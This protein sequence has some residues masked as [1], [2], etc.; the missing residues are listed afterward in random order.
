[1]RINKYVVW[2]IIFGV[3][4]LFNSY[5]LQFINN[6]KYAN[7]IIYFYLILSMYRIRSLY[8][9]LLLEKEI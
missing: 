1:M 4:C 5:D 6:F 7:I 3:I 2:S 9:P 8:M